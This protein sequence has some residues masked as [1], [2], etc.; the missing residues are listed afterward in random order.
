MEEFKFYQLLTPKM[1]TQVIDTIFKDFKLN[2]R[3]FF[4]PL[5]RGFVNEAIIQLLAREYKCTSDQ[6]IKLERPQYKMSQIYFIMQGGFGLYNP[7]AVDNNVHDCSDPFLIIRR[8]S[9]YGDY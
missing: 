6:R 3:Y 9:V 7:K 4:D 5:D 2:F 1:Q 8:Y